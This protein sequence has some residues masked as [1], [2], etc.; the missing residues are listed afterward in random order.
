MMVFV[1]RYAG[2][3]ED[4]FVQIPELMG[5]VSCVDDLPCLFVCFFFK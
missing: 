1:A 2:A 4:C 3:F 5:T